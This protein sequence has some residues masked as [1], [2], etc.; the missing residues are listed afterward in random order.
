MQIEREVLSAAH[1][2]V[3]A[4]TAAPCQPAQRRVVHRRRA[5]ASPCLSVPLASCLSCSRTCCEQPTNCHGT[6]PGTRVTDVSAGWW[7]M[8]ISWKTSIGHIL[9]RASHDSLC[10]LSCQR[11]LDPHYQ[12]A[13]I[14]VNV[15]ARPCNEP[16]APY[17]DD[18]SVID[19]FSTQ[20]R[21]DCLLISRLLLLLVFQ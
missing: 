12:A 16:K 2:S 15:Q 4:W 3:H 21:Q 9:W 5:G 10:L 20:W 7:L 6:V 13:Q 1:L 8:K 14:P 17:S 19:T 18:C 11:P